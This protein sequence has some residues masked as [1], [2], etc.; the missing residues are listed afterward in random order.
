MA[1]A[2]AAVIGVDSAAIA[3][4]VRDNR[5]TFSDVIVQG[6]EKGKLVFRFDDGRILR[7]GLVFIR[8]VELKTSRPAGGD[9]LSRADTLHLA[10]NHVQAIPVYDRARQL[11]TH[12]WIKTYATLKLLQCCDADGRFDDVITHYVDLARTTPELAKDLLPERYPK[13]DAPEY[14]RALQRIDGLMANAPPRVVAE[15]LERLRRSL[16]AGKPVTKLVDDAGQASS[17]PVA[18]PAASRPSDDRG[19]ANREALPRERRA[20]ARV[21]ELLLEGH[22]GEAR[23]LVESALKT[24]PDALRDVWWLAD[25]ECR[26]VLNQPDLAALAALK[27]IALTPDSVY[28]GEA[29]FV[30]G[31]AY[32]SL[33]PGK[34]RA[35]FEDCL[36]H[37]TTPSDVRK[38]AVDHLAQLRAPGGGS[39]G[40]GESGSGGGGGT[41]GKKP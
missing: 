38:E 34:A 31:K 30:A 12:D 29:L 27:V 25:A 13:R 18:G 15:S 9:E 7:R 35:L 6:I 2:V 37:P 17:R 36:R 20:T 14:A 5:G 21:Y 10:G 39:N 28:F 32:E 16:V 22:A 3:D 40:G 23:T 26:L 4:E 11:A 24:Q 8:K 33:R 1:C 41:G 19:D